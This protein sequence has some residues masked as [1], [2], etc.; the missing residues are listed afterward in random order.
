LRRAQE[1]LLNA[2]PYHETL[3]RVADSLL[4]SDPEALAPAENAQRVALILVV[5]LR[6][7]HC[8]AAT[9]RTCCAWPK[10]PRA[11][12]V[13]EGLTVKFFADRPQVARSFSA[14]P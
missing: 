11:T 10:R 9:T 2:R 13:A 8:A 1:A 12:S 14:Q 3:K 7:R 4:G 5:I 6:P